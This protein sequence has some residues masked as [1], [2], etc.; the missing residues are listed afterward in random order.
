MTAN[1]I[2]SYSIDRVTVASQCISLLLPPTPT[3]G[4]GGLIVGFRF[5]HQS[6]ELELFDVTDLLRFSAAV[7]GEAGGAVDVGVGEWTTC[8]AI[9]VGVVEVGVAVRTSSS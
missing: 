2:T 8:V 9:H 7:A 4:W 5:T 1:C 3:I 6:F